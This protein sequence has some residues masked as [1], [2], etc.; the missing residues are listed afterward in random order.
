MDKNKIP[1][2][3]EILKELREIGKM[4]TPEVLENATDEELMGYVFMIEKI[5][6]QAKHNKEIK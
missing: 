1:D 4:I 6:Y 5:K 3:N 2:R